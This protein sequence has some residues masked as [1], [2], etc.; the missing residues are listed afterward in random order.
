MHRPYIFIHIPK[1]GGQSIEKTLNIIWQPIHCHMMFN[2]YPKYLRDRIFS[3]TIVRN[4]FDRIVSAYS[5][6]TQKLGNI[7]DIEFYEEH[8]SKHQNFNEFVKDFETNPILQDW[9]HFIPMS[10]FIA[11]EIRF[12]GRYENLQNDFDI[13]CDAINVPKVEL[14]R[15]NA[16]QH[17]HY[18]EFYNA[19]SIKIV[20]NFYQKDLDKFGYSF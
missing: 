2:Q 14:E 7:H 18:S 13:I 6:L 15:R 20:E 17:A 10:D 11:P 5:Y 8:L 12:V 4:P 19:E 16:S 1:T 3:F 9:V